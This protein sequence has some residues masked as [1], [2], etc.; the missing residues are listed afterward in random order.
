[1]AYNESKLISDFSFLINQLWE[2]V[3]LSLFLL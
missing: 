1:M 2:S 3:E